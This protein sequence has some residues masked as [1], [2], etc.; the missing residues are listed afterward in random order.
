MSIST[1]DDFIR[2]GLWRSLPFQGNRLGPT[3][4]CALKKNERMT[5]T[6]KYAQI[7]VSCELE[8]LFFPFFLL[9]CTL[10]YYLVIISVFFYVKRLGRTHKCASKPTFRS[11]SQ[12]WVSPRSMRKSRPVNSSVCSFLFFLLLCTLEYYLL[13]ISVFLR[14]AAGSNARVCVKADVSVRVARLGLTQKY[15]QIS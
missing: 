15:A 1:T 6:H 7:V 10:E 14:Q 5:L 3:Q 2:K 8:C 9:L 4:K 13:I 12:G 11:E